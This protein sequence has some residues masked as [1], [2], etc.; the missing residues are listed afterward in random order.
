MSADSTVFLLGAGFS[1]CL[2]DG[3]MPLMS[4]FFD[5]LNPDRFP[6]L[7]RF[8]GDTAGPMATANVEEVIGLL[9]Q[10]SDSP[11]TDMGSLA[12]C[13]GS[14]DGVRC[15]LGDYCLD[16]LCCGRCALG[17]GP[18]AS[19]PART[20]IRPSSPR[21]TTICRRASSPQNKW[22]P[23]TE[24]SSRRATTARTSP[25]LLH[26]CECAGDSSGTRPPWRGSV[27]KL[28]GSVAWKTCLNPRCRQHECLVA[29]QHCRPFNGCPCN[30]CG[31]PCRP[32]IVLPS[33]KKHYRK[34][35]PPRRDVGFGRGRPERSGRTVHLRIF[36]P[37]ERLPGADDV[38]GWGEGLV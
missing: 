32:V 8:V 33:Q 6:L 31:Q 4:G 21:T 30:C 29:D 36:L 13:A 10:L 9:D 25:Y 18:P 3:A 16:R 37:H 34:Y 28:H 5:L 17:T 20:K 1:R 12:C 2:T 23:P 26:D 14:E 15:E 11:L 22:T 7:H 24:V 19:S 27:L 38:Q 35:P